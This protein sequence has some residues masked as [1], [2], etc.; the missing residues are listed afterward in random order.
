MTQLSITT[1][2]NVNISFA[3]ATVGDRILAS[4]VD[5][6][7]KVAYFVIVFLVI[8]DGLGINDKISKLDNWSAMAIY[9]M[10]MLPWVFYTLVQES[11]FEGQT[12]GK[13]LLKI[14]VVKID[15][16]QASFTEYLMR[17]F[18]RIVDI[19]TF[20]GIVAIIT[21][22]TTKKSQRLGDMAAGTSVIT[23]K[24]KIDISHTILEEIDNHYFPTYPMVIKLSDNDVRI[25][26]E[27][28]ASAQARG[29][30]DT[31]LKLVNK[32]ESVTG[33]RN[34]SGNNYDFLRTVLKDYN[35]YTRGV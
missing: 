17:W 16:Y 7:V 32:I 18:M 35:F 14:K 28:F 6:L 19:W 4:L 5:L 10:L 11:I 21:V 33:I 34:Q 23:L 20:N 13:R 25:I 24:N 2:Q 29:D 12:L 1:T 15:G 26:K 9:M 8:I 22:A 27:T 31:I 30:Y 3:A